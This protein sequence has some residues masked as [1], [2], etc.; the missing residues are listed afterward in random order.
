MNWQNYSIDSFFND[1][2][3]FQQMWILNYISLFFLIYELRIL[4][5]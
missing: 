5:W 3:L 2:L 1:V 4:I